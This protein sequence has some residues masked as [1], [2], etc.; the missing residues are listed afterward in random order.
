MSRKTSTI[1][2][3]IY[4]RIDWSFPTRITRLNKCVL[5]EHAQVNLCTSKN[6]IKRKKMIT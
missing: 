3:T 5:A 2:L 6:A 4:K 1:T